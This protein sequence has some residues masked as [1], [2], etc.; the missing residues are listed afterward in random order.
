MEFVSAGFVRIYRKSH[1]EST[2]G[3]VSA[4]R[5]Y[6]LAESDRRKTEIKKQKSQKLPKGG[7]VSCSTA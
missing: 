7:T 6:V 4:D 5:L 1:T 3:A 2:V